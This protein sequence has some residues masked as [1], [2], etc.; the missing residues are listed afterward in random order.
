MLFLIATVLSEIINKVDNS[1]EKDHYTAADFVFLA[2]RQKS[3]FAMLLS[4]I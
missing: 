2:R 4:Q 1:L 3:I